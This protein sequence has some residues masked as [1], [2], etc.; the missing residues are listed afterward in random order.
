MKGKICGILL[1][2]LTAVATHSQQPRWYFYLGKVGMGVGWGYCYEYY[3]EE[4]VSLF[5]IHFGGPEIGFFK[6]KSGLGV[7]CAEG[8][9]I[10][11]EDEERW[12]WGCFLFFPV[13]FYR[14]PFK[15]PIIFEISAGIPG[16]KGEI[17]Y[18]F[19]PFPA[20]MSWHI[21]GYYLGEEWGFSTALNLTVGL[22][23][24]FC[25]STWY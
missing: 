11:K 23:R 16:L 3:R 24:W 13:K 9:L 8:Y 7:G 19:A 12:R 14:Q 2:V 10:G 22:G 20:E 6:G 5:N 17:R 15:E 21:G 4:Y 18:V 1:G 25:K